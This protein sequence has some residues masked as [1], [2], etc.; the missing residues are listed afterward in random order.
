MDI[1][2]ANLHKQLETSHENLWNPRIPL[3]KEL[4]IVFHALHA[5]AG[6]SPSHK[7][8]HCSLL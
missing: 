1:D 7:E 2:F 8:G 5:S 4:V 3:S 6:P